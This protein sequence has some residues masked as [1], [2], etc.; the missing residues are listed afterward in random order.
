MEQGILLGSY[1]VGY[2]ITCLPGDY[3]AETF[4]GM[5]VVLVSTV[6]SGTLTALI[7]FGAKVNV[8]LVIVMRFLIGL[9][10]VSFFP[11]F[12]HTII[13]STLTGGCLSCS[14]SSIKGLGTTNRRGKIWIVSHGKHYWNSSD[15][16]TSGRIN[17]KNRLDVG[18]Y[19]T[20]CNF[21]D[22]VRCLVL[23]CH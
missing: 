15:I 18:F 1:Y 21:V 12:I 17:R 16:S 23:Y 3:L 9:A 5:L 8:W 11:H 22:V 14:T 10:S 20:W 6:C 19:N 7:P 13:L 4:G 2:F